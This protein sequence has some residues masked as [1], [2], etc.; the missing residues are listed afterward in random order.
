VGVVELDLVDP[1]RATPAIG[2]YSGSPR[3]ELP[4]TVYLPAVDGAAPLILLAHGLNG[5]P[6]KFTSLAR[7]WAEAGYVVAVPRFPVSSDEFPELDSIAFDARIADLP[8]QAVDVSFVIDAIGTLGGRVDRRRLG[9]YGL[10]LGSLTVWSTVARN[11][12]ATASIHGLIQSDGGFPGDVASLS[13]APFPV[14]VAHSDIDPLFPI[15]G[16]LE[17]FEALPNPRYLL[18]LHG[19]DH[20]AVGENS[21]TPADEAYRIATTVFWDRCLGGDGDATFPQDVTVAGVATF[22]DGS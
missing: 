13:E 2:R 4:T 3:R 9:L 14:F 15:E 16:V 8:E 17:E 11:G 21:P 10:S 20:A 19:A 22:V 6:R 1:E 18:V 12:L 7:R 5:H